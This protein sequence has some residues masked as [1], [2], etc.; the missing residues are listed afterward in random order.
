MFRGA[1][2]SERPIK[3]KSAPSVNETNV[4]EINPRELYSLVS[5]PI[6]ATDFPFDQYS[7]IE[8][9]LK[10]DDED[11]G[12][13]LNE[14]LVL[15]DTSKETNWNMFFVDPDKDEFAYKITY[16]AVDHKDIEGQWVHTSDKRITIRDPF[17]NKRTLQ[18]FPNVDWARVSQIFVDI[19]YEDRENNVTEEASLSFDSS[20]AVAQ[21]FSVDLVNREKRQ[22]A[23]KVT[24]LFKDA[25]MREMPTSVTLDKR[26][27]IRED[28]RAHRV[29]TIG[30][31]DTLDFASKKLKKIEL[32]MRFADADAGIDV[33]DKFTITANSGEFVFEYDIADENKSSYEY[34]MFQLFENGMTKRSEW[35]SSDEPLLLIDIE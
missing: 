2:N 10:Y 7:H 12:V 34:Q 1:D 31:A 28:M 19:T 3:L 13:S 18:V 23:F 25:T 15:S 11:N 16:R 8:V 20:T 9:S 22:L 6:V 35:I 5:V 24:M 4:W 33:A 29:V 30:V 17:P 27:I 21:T 32:N 14:N 26:L